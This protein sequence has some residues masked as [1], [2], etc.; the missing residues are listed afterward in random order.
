[1]GILTGKWYLDLI[2]VVV[3]G[4]V[5]IMVVSWLLGAFALNG[6]HWARFL[7]PIIAHEPSWDYHT[8]I[9]LT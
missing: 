4:I 2:I 1:M 6:W 8:L 5:V 9:S 7:D 3:I